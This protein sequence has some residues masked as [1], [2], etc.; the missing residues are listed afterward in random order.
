MNRIPI[1]AT[2]LGRI[3][4]ISGCEINYLVPSKSTLTI[5]DIAAGL[6]KES[7]FAGQTSTFYS[8]AQHSVL[9]MALAPAE[10][11]MAAL[12]HDASEAF[13][14]DI[15]S[16]LKTL[17]P[18]Y[19]RIEKELQE[20]IL[21]V[22]GIEIEKQEAIK[23]YDHEALL[24][25]EEYLFN[26]RRGRFCEIMKNFGYGDLWIPEIAENIWTKQFILRKGGF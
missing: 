17:L 21:S 22:C 14:K 13:M 2:D 12:L 7:R 1:T 4:T 6:S 8:V 10:L 24:I 5:K 3:N 15:P 19:K 11:S 18:D 16:P 20:H 9:V 26:Y 23:K 25:E